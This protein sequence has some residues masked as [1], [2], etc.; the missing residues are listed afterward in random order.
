MTTFSAKTGST[1]ESIPIE[2]YKLQFGSTTYT[3]TSS[4]ATVTVGGFT[5]VPEP[6]L[7]RNKIEV[8]KTQTNQFLELKVS[9]DNAFV[10]QYFNTP[11][12]TTG[13]S[14]DLFLLQA[15]DGSQFLSLRF[16]GRVR[17][18]RFVD[19]RTVVIGV[20][21]LLKSRI[22]QIPNRGFQITCPNYLGDADCGVNLAVEPFTVRRTVTA[23]DGIDLTIP[24]LSS[25]PDGYY[26]SGYVNV[27][28]TFDF[29]D[30]I[31][32]V[33]DVVTV[34]SGFR[35][36]IV[37]LTIDVV[38]GCNHDGTATGDCKVKF[39]NRRNFGGTLYVPVQNP[40]NDSIIY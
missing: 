24:G 13:A 6:G 25:Q 40:T 30:I 20:Q 16:K 35:D 9:I 2:L 19:D 38:T 5:Y 26:T 3:Y 28:G 17:Y 36:S 39:D 27:V 34:F 32:H 10:R 29:R 8:G 33:G 14:L 12:S 23:V 21:P 37:G 7:I 18:V 4:E 22:R 31:S 11:P 15:F 1:Y